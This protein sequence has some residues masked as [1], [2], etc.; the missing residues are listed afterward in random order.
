MPKQQKSEYK[1]L[2][3]VFSALKGSQINIQ[4]RSNIEIWGTIENVDKNMNIELSNA[5]LKH[6]RSNKSGVDEKYELILIQS[7][8]IRYIQIPDKIDLNSLLFL[9]SKSMAEMKKKYQRS[10]RKPVTLPPVDSIYDP[11]KD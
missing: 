8:N 7:R 9:Y 4:L 5:I 6:N 1:S 11:T 10:K 2:G 3:C